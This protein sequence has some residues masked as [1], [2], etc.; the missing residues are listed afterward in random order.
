MIVQTP[1]PTA[2]FSTHTGGLGEVQRRDLSD[3]TCHT[4]STTSGTGL[5]F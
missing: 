1:I 4:W 3:F 2:V 5:E